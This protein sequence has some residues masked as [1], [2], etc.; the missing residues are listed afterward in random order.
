M[1]LLGG[2]APSHPGQTFGMDSNWV[3]RHVMDSTDR[4]AGVGAALD[5]LFELIEQGEVEQAQTAI[6]HLR[7][8]IGEHPEL[9]EAQALVTRYTRWPESL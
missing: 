8:S 9:V 3:L 2:G 1:I 4:D 5:A 7:A 6:D